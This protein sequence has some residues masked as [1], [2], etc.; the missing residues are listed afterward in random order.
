MNNNTTLT[1][2]FL[3]QAPRP[4]AQVLQGLPA[5]EAA[6]LIESIPARLAAPVTVEMIP[7]QAARVLER[8]STARAAMILRQLAFADAIT[9]ARQV[10]AVSR[11]AIFEELPSRF[12][13][14][15][16][17][18]LTYPRHQVG[19]WID[20]E[21]PTLSSEHSVS[22][23]LRLFRAAD[24]SSHLFVESPGH[25]GYLGVLSIR[26]VLR[27]EPTTRLEHLTIS[28]TKPILNRASL[29]SI[30]FDERWDEML[31]LPVVGRRGN[32]L[33][34]VSR[35]SMRVAMHLQHGIE[36]EPDVSFVRQL[37]AALAL[38]SSGVAQLISNPGAWAHRTADEG[39]SGER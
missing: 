5:D 37:F 4:A 25:D 24:N 21:V 15:L 13:Q 17:G 26:Q 28:Q 32:L 30:A 20:P 36:R 9:L 12:A 38:T 27:S 22:D 2:A 16:V 1:L 11:E 8:V 14:R 6:L 10:A 33:G 3:Q 39:V 34:G 18:A 19:A 35:R 31:H 7:W 29:S 23:A